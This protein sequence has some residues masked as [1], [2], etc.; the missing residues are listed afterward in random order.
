MSGTRRHTHDVITPP[1]AGPA[2]KG[3][4]GCRSEPLEDDIAMNIAVND[5][6]VNIVLRIRVKGEVIVIADREASSN[7]MFCVANGETLQKL[8][9]F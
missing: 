5:V 1:A 7:V 4:H 2:Y 6:A 3:Y 8:V 9:P